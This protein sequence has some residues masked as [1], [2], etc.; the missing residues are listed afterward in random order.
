MIREIL[1][2]KTDEGM[3]VNDPSF[4]NIKL[5]EY[6]FSA[7]RMGMPSLTATLNYYR[8]LDKE[9][10]KK[11]YVEFRGERY[12]IRNVPNSSKTNSDVVYKHSLEFRSQRD[13]I[14]SNVYFCDA[15]Y[16]EATLS[17]WKPCS[18]STTG[19]FYGT[20]DEFADRL[21]CVFRYVGVGD[22]ILKQK[23]TLTIDDDVVGDGYCAIVD[24]SGDYDYDKMINVEFSDQTLWE[25]LSDVFE[26]DEMPFEFRGRRIIFGAPTKTISH[27]FKLGPC[28][29]LLSISK[30]NANAKIVNRVTMLG[31]SENLPYYYPNET[32]YGHVELYM[33][34]NKY[35]N[36]H[37]VKI[38]NMSQLLASILPDTPITL[39]K[40]GDEQSYQAT[41]IKLNFNNEAL[42]DYTLNDTIAL[43]SSK[44]TP[45][46]PKVNIV[47]NF[48][49]PTDGDY[50]LDR[51]VGRMWNANESKPMAD[52]NFVKS[53]EVVALYDETIYPSTE[54]AAPVPYDTGFL[55]TGLKKGSYSLQLK[56][57]AP[58]S[59]N[60]RGESTIY[61]Q[62]TDIRFID[63]DMT[64]KYNTYYW[65]YQD[66]T[67]GSI[68]QL[69]IKI[70]QEL[71]DAM[72]GDSFGWTGKERM[73]FQTNLM[74]PI[75]RKTNGDERFYN[76]VNDTY[77]DENGEYYDFKNPFIEGT[78]RE[79]IYK[80]ED[81]K[82]TI[83]GIVNTSQAFFGSIADIA[84]DIDDNDSL[85]SDATEESDKNDAK[86]YEHSF[87]YIK[88]NIFD[89]EYGFD[90]F[91]S[92][93]QNEPMTL[94]ITSGS[95]AGCKF[96]IQAIEFTDETG[97][98]SFK[99]P[100]QT[101]GPNGYIVNGGYAEKVKESEFQDWQQNTMTHQIWV[102]VQKDAETFGV[103]MP[104]RLHN[105]MPSV[106]DTFNIINIDLPQVYI[107]A[108]EKKL[109]AEGIK[110]MSENN[111]DKF[112]FDI[113]AS[114]IFFANHLEVLSEIDE[115]VELIV[116]YN[117]ADY[118]LSVSSLQVSCKDNEAL[119]EIKIS[120]T[121]N[122]TVGE[123]FT[124]AIADKV[125]QT[126]GKGGG[127]VGYPSL[128][129][130]VDPHTA[131]G[132]YLNKFRDD[133][134]VGKIASDTGF[135][136]GNFVS[137]SAGGSFH[138][139]STD[140]ST[141]LETDYLHVRKKAVF[142]ELEIA[143]ISTIGGSQLITP[144][145]G[146]E[147]LNVVN[148]GN[149]YRCYFKSAEQTEDAT[150]IANC[151]FKEGDLVICREFNVATGISTQAAN[152]FYWQA[153]LAVDNDNGYVDITKTD[154]NS[155][156]GVPMAGDTLVQLGNKNDTSR[157]SAIM[158][159]TSLA[160]PP[161]ITL[162]NGIKTYTLMNCEVIQMGVDSAMP[163]FN[164]Y[165]NFFFGSKNSKDTYLKYDS[166][167]K[168]LSYRGNLDIES[169]VGDDSLQDYIQN[170]V[171]PGFVVIDTDGEW[172]QANIESKGNGYTATW[173]FAD[174]ISDK[175]FKRGDNIGIRIT[176]T[177]LNC[178]TILIIE[179]ISVDSATSITGT[180]KG[181]IQNG[182]NGEDAVVY[183]IEPSSTIV[184]RDLGATKVTPERI[185][186][187]GY[188]KIGSNAK[189][190]L[191]SPLI[192]FRGY[193]I[194]GDKIGTDITY[195]PQSKGIHYLPTY[196]KGYWYL[197]DDDENLL[198]VA[199]TVT[200]PDQESYRAKFTVTD[201]EIKSL[202]ERQSTFGT[203]LST[204]TQT[205][206]SI[207]AL[208]GKDGGYGNVL[209]NSNGGLTGWTNGEALETTEEGG[210]WADTFYKHTVTL[211]SSS[212]IPIIGSNTQIPMT[213]DAA[214]PIKMKLL[215]FN[216]AGFSG[217]SS[218]WF[219][220]KQRIYVDG[221][222][223]SH[224]G[225]VF[226]YNPDATIKPSDIPNIRPILTYGDLAGENLA[227]NG[228]GLKGSGLYIDSQ[229]ILLK[230]DIVDILGSLSLQGKIIHPET[231][232]NIANADDYI[233][234]VAYLV[235]S[236]ARSLNEDEAA[237]RGTANSAAMPAA[238]DGVSSNVI[239]GINTGV[240]GGGGSSN[241]NIGIGSNPFPPDQSVVFEYIDLSILP[242]LNIV[243]KGENAAVTELRLP[244]YSHDVA[245]PQIVMEDV[246]QQIGNTITLHNLTGKTLRI[247][248][249]YHADAT[250]THTYV[251]LDA[252]QIVSATCQVY[253][254]GTAANIVWLLNTNG[255]GLIG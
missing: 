223:Y 76:A 13:E 151:R 162:Y 84:Y 54:I 164:C 141:Y 230:S 182:Q 126:V 239:S 186:C 7:T 72:I 107:D 237:A 4:F 248:N 43:Y 244:S 47:L 178:A 124:Q 188:V 93:S 35:L 58:Q 113:G 85:T 156:G 40:Y 131:D 101:S 127:T 216:R 106:D 138:Q 122:I 68:G 62:L 184:Y 16:D 135:E 238:D 83:E 26:N 105:Y 33:G 240:S 95:C 213:M 226:R 71:N 25:V 191:F 249:I 172:T 116:R 10:T 201:K 176:N 78:P 77:E 32:E 12:Y 140:G 117:D 46:N 229:R 52:T 17:R 128:S 80:N 189:S 215:Y 111:E 144:G 146:I 109:E 236:N 23:T 39:R 132:R 119:P 183:E 92:A 82:P 190:E 155:I 29:E 18:N 173:S 181:Y 154:T 217:A 220:N 73:P 159:S 133:R 197:Y 44:V 175:N 143:R 6:E 61:V 212:L 89:G 67:F 224:F 74:P 87:F 254:T 152:R 45:Y 158:L 22:S 48:S 241:G 88:L 3:G 251:N 246:K 81:I 177:T 104:N 31:S 148:I 179:I 136:V 235:G 2:I 91:K 64:D 150:K 194:N 219:F 192:I 24:K 153:V 15:V 139:D 30:Q 129:E 108:A 11:E 66:R 170:N 145:G 204:V 209:D 19:S 174:D 42:K 168:Q 137:G 149:A 211:R 86:K 110:Y 250:G 185:T 187:K 34:K 255:I 28:Q 99:N 225:V 207:Q 38:A 49:V 118:K 90:L 234:R 65:E 70:E 75:Y 227:S 210:S 59:H 123:S 100:V 60:G 165:G 5:T 214:V 20:I 202:T 94:Q 142:A 37:I 41:S 242:S 171:V 193:D 79:Y 232:F 1:K 163:F 55:M 180:T 200:C 112:T 203:N 130:N 196:D 69:G 102:C 121:D 228:T 205:A 167:T 114:R 36:E 63:A 147:I 218:G 27:V 206:D 222:N 231:V 120:L 56:I 96:K 253:T 98:K 199:V 9:W 8:C 245:M 21:N 195:D 103:I 166:A 161:S 125:I 134:S 14:L 252:N 198:A 243:L 51:I 53:F 160:N 97:L 233:K 208:V 57:N 50:I 157:Q 169:K 221:Y 247:Y 115:Y